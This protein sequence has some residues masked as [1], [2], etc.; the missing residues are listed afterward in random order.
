[1]P[2]TEPPPDLITATIS[3]TWR[4][5][6][7]ELVDHIMSM[8]KNDLRS[9]KACS[10]TCKVMVASARRLIHRKICLSS[11]KNWEL[12][13]F[14]ERRAYLSGERLGLAVRVLS[15]IAA[16]GLLSYARQLSINLD[17]DFTPANLHPYNH[18]FQC[19]D[20]IQELSIS[21]L[22]TQGFLKG[23]DTY[24]ANFVPTLRS[25]HLDGPTGET[26]DIL[27][28]ICRFP[29]LDDLTLKVPI[30][31]DPH[32][33]RTWRAGSLPIVK[34]VPPFRGR[35]KLDG[36]IEG[37]GYVLQ[38][39]I[40]LP[41][42]RRFRSIDFRNCEFE[43]EQPIVDACCGTLDSVSTTWGKFSKC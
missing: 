32:D 31:V 20:R 35:L 30:S 28:F 39:L 22:D 21:R 38:Q 9:L 40:S 17:W 3:G 36:I 18:H 13:T 11:E 12:L 42:E 8:L 34:S 26:Q 6:P 1:M 5:L 43:A 25:L 27:N 10:A 29:H 33:R 14:E 19:F 16:H 7:Q 23:F 2:D 15:E 37:R 41:G 24:F 4:V